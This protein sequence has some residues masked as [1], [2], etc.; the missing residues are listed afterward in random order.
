MNINPVSQYFELVTGYPRNHYTH[1]L[2]QFSKKK[3]GTYNQG[4]FIKGQQTVNTTINTNGINDGSYPVQSSNTSNVNVV[5]S[6]N[7][8]QNIPSATTGKITPNS[9]QLFI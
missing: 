2:E 5:N 1:K 6:T 4:I 9:G 8:I 7:V 3:Y